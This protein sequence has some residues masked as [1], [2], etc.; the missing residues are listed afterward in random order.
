MAAGARVHGRRREDHL[1]PNYETAYWVC[2]RCKVGFAYGDSLERHNKL[3]HPKKHEREE[4]KRMRAAAEQNRRAAKH[5]ELCMNV[6][7]TGL[8]FWRYMMAPPPQ[9]LKELEKHHE[10]RDWSRA[11][12]ALEKFETGK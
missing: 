6:V 7:K 5:R 12:A 9:T 8:A 1:R 10:A 2:K 3:K 4:S 11:C